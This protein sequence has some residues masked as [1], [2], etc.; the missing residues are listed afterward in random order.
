MRLITFN[1]KPNSP[2]FMF[3]DKAWIWPEIVQANPGLKDVDVYTVR[4]I[5]VEGIRETDVVI[6]QVC[7]PVNI[8]QV[9]PIQT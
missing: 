5:M 7:I 6:D 3:T 4:D 8:N 9:P 1:L 2:A